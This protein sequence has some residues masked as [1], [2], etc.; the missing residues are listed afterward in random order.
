MPRIIAETLPKNQTINEARIRCCSLWVYLFHPI[1]RTVNANFHETDIQR[2][3]HATTPMICNANYN[4]SS[5]AK[6]VN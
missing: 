2:R 5:K 4:P 6:V 3:H 1:R